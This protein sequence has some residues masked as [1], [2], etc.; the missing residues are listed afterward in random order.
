MKEREWEKEIKIK[1]YKNNLVKESRKDR[2]MNRQ[3]IMFKKGN[4]RER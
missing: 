2:K 3:K 4:K 1:K